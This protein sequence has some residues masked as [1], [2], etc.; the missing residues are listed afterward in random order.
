MVGP[1]GQVPI[2]A[3]LK[4]SSEIIKSNLAN[5][6][7]GQVTPLHLWPIH[8]FRCPL[9]RGD[10]IHHTFPWFPNRSLGTRGRYGAKYRM[11]LPARL[12]LT[13][14]DPWLRSA[15]NRD[16]RIKPTVSDCN[17]QT[18]CTYYSPLARIYR[19][20]LR[21]NSVRA[22]ASGQEVSLGRHL[23]ECVQLTINAEGDFYVV[24]QLASGDER[25]I[26]AV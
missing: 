7:P 19:D 25:G 1:F 23:C 21:I 18:F 15:R 4:A 16:A 8:I 24:H 14:S 20:G 6:Q 26:E 5:Q 9:T 10:D 11:V 17:C 3:Y 2:T 12:R 22:K 13:F